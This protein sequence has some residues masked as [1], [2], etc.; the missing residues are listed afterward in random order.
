MELKVLNGQ[1]LLGGNR[2]EHVVFRVRYKLART[3]RTFRSEYF[4]TQ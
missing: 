3:R 2:N 1:I 4:K